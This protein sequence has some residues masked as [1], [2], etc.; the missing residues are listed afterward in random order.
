VECFLNVSLFRRCGTT[1]SL[2]WFVALTLFAVS[3][4]A[5]VVRP[6]GPLDFT[7]FSLDLN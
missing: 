4:E 5:F 3:S 1:S 7:R 2:W 6:P